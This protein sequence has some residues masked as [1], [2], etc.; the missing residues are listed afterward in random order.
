ME[1]VSSVFSFW[2]LLIGIIAV[3]YL[4]Q[5]YIETDESESPFV[6][7][8]KSFLRCIIISKASDYLHVMS[9]C[10]HESG[11]GSGLPFFNHDHVM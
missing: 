6:R 2:K 11:F 7:Y 5:L 1:H 10:Y 9:A 8:K 3:F 4:C